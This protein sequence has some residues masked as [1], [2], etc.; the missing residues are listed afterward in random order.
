M[1]CHVSSCHYVAHRHILVTKHA[2]LSLPG[3]HVTGVLFSREMAAPVKKTRVRAPRFKW[4]GDLEKRFLDAIQEYPLLWDTQDS[5]YIEKDKRVTALET[6]AKALGL[7][8]G[9]YISFP[10]AFHMCHD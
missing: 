10:D 1:R 7:E 5:Q 3:C 6:I 4:P 2:T 8:S 9:E